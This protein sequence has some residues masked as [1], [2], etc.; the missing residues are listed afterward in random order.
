MSKQ[1]KSKSKK[2]HDPSICLN[3]RASRSYALGERLEAGLQLRGTEVK[4]CRSGD[5]HLNDAYVQ[6]IR[7]EAFLVNAHI[8][9]YAYGNQL[10]HEPGR[11][12]KLLLHRREIDKLSV[13]I[14]ERGATVI[15]LR[16]YFK[17][18]RVKAEIALA[19]GKTHTDRRQD[20]KN[21]DAQREIQ[22]AMRR[23]RS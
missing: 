1:T 10:N 23:R 12:R 7:G 17:N 20:I 4:A 22:R 19:T 18:G 3:R 15:P 5:A 8:A 21:R 14:H 13:K 2:G 16:L 6:I 11:P 9:E